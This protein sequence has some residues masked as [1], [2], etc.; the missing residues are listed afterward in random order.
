MSWEQNAVRNAK[1]VLQCIVYDPLTA[2]KPG[3]EVRTMQVWWVDGY[4]L[5]L[6]VL[7]TMLLLILLVVAG[8]ALAP[9]AAA[10]GPEGSLVVAT[11]SGGP[12]YA[13]EAN[14]SGL[15]YLTS[16]M[17]PALSPDGRWVAFTRW[18]GPQ[19]GAPGSLW[20]VSADGTGERLV[21][22][23]LHQPRSPVW[24]PDGSQISL[25]VQQGG[26][27][28]PEYKCSKTLPADPLMADA[29]GD[30]IRAV[31]DAGEGDVE[32]RYCYT[33]L[34]HPN[35]RLRVVDVA[36]GSFQDL[37]GDLF[38]LAPAWDPANA[39]RV[40][41]EG[42][43]GLVNLDLNQGHTW[44]LTEDPNDHTPVF[45]PDGSRIAVSYWQLDHWEIHV[46]NADGSG[47]VRLTETPLRVIVEDRLQGKDTRAW[48]N[49][50]PAWSPDG[51]QIAFLTDRAGEWQV[52]VM[53]AD[54]SGQRAL[55]PG[56]LGDGLR[57]DYH[58]VGEQVLSWR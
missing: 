26:R 56:A 48:N 32:V 19:H 15:R 39:W 10:Q 53:E 29:D 47:R 17:D 27:L 6:R 42:E 3:M 58:A 1:R 8:L 13:L 24:S 9:S 28:A 4:R 43:I 18:D 25:S 41:Y 22:D 46:L 7:V 35:W 52:W 57:L 20:V 51:S 49:A 2:N 44:A 40:V 55:L 34:A 33:L 38:S 12:I 5:A 23:G 54:G 21:L 30:Y 36:S 45:S 16:G 11:A 31:V 37:P 14:G 50:A